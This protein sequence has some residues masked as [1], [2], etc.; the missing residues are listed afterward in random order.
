MARQPAAPIYLHI[1]ETLEQEIH[2]GD[3][4]AGTRLDSEAKLAARFD[5]NRHTVRQALALLQAKGLVHRVKGHGAFVTPGRLV[6]RIGRD[7]SF[8]NSV[9]R[10]GLRNAQ[11]IIDIARE[12]AG[13]A[14]ADALALEVGA[15]VIRLRRVRYAGKIPFGSSTN[16][17]RQ[18]AS[19]RSK[20]GCERASRQPASCCADTTAS[21]SCA[22][23]PRSRSSRQTGSWP[24]SSASRSAP[25]CFACRALTFSPITPQPSGASP[26]FAVTRHGSTSMSCPRTPDDRDAAADRHHQ[27][28]SPVPRRP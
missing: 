13:T 14:V 11:R 18:S 19:R 15:P 4:Q 28:P 21:R 25:H 27:L 17:T 16:P 3:P 2:A 7:M 22:P 5:V 24:T 8:S 23:T 1:A 9:A 12:P 20:S 26:G 6:Y 10:L